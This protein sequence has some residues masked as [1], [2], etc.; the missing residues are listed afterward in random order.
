MQSWRRQLL[1]K[2][3]SHH[4]PHMFPNAVSTASYFFSYLHSPSKQGSLKRA[5]FCIKIFGLDFKPSMELT[6]FWP[7]RVCIPDSLCH[8]T[9]K[10]GEGKQGAREKASAWRLWHD[11]LGNSIL[12]KIH[13]SF[14]QVLWWEPT[15]RDRDH[16]AVLRLVPLVPFLILIKG[17]KV[18]IPRYPQGQRQCLLESPSPED[19]KDE[20][21]F[22]LFRLNPEHT[23]SSFV[24]SRRWF[25]KRLSLE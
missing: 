15:A 17:K 6:T 13:I 19:F 10:G 22:S 16:T 25:L 23:S 18:L 21:N 7:W 1:G 2:M 9:Y 4:V 11:H 5:P 14:L 8:L 12:C 24:I 20:R 3:F